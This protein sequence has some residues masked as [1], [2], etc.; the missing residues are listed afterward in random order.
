MTS[1]KDLIEMRHDSRISK[2]PACDGIVICAQEL[3]H[4]A[5][6]PGAMSRQGDWDESSYP[7]LVRDV[8]LVESTASALLVPCLLLRSSSP[9]SV[10]W[11][12]S[13]AREMQDRLLQF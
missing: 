10:E 7:E 4:L 12:D 9:L 11:A 1:R 8:D 2:P 3:P 6:L 5:I 13:S